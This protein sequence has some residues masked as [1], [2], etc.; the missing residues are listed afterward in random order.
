ME[1]DIKR[2]GLKIT[3]ENEEELLKPKDHPP[4]SIRNGL[5]TIEIEWWKILEEKQIAKRARLIMEKMRL[6]I[7]ETITNKT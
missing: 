6:F 4:F 5:S 2:S 3:K 7:N 1:M